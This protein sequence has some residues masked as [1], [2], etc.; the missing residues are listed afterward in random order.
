MSTSPAIRHFDSHSTQSTGAL[1]GLLATA[2][3]KR[4]KS[5]QPSASST[6]SVPADAT[7]HR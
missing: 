7:T 4:P 3:T 6:L 2:A 5:L 1:A